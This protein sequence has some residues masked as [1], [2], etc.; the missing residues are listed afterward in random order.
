MD[1]TTVIVRKERVGQHMADH[2]S[3][4][5]SGQQIGVFCMQHGPGS[6]NSFGGVA[7]AYS[8]SSPIVVLPMGYPRTL[9]Q[10]QPNFPSALNYRHITKSC[11]QLLIPQA[12]PDAMRRAF[13]AA[14]NGRPRPALVE[15]PGD[16]MHEEGADPMSYCPTVTA[17]TA[18]T[19]RSPQVAEVLIAAER[20]VIY[21]GQG[22]TM[23]R[24]GRN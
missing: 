21:A 24:P 12:V 19:R 4:M 1:I 17:V 2:C 13:S 15:I 23:P 3:R 6:E 5:S 11:E 10:V 9:S 20:P 8:E 14:R 7:Q 16:L 18:C 22:I